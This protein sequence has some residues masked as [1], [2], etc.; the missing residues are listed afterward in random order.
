[1]EFFQNVFNTKGKLMCQLLAANNEEVMVK[2]ATNELFDKALPK[3]LELAV[4]HYTDQEAAETLSALYDMTGSFAK[5][6]DDHTRAI[7]E[8]KQLI[9]QANYPPWLLARSY[10]TDNFQCKIVQKA[11]IGELPKPKFRIWKRI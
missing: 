3:Y 2:N 5:T 7:L 11:T 6:L 9:K 1:M 10:E 4:K 8:L